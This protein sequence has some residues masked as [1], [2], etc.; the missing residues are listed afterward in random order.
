MPVTD[1]L[2]VALTKLMKIVLDKLTVDKLPSTCLHQL[3]KNVV[4]C[5]VTLSLCPH[6]AR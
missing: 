1:L 5:T 6:R 4:I 3:V 2:Q